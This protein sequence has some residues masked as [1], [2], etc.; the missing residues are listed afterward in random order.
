MADYNYYEILG[1]DKSASDDDIKAAYRK[2]AKKYHPDLYTTKSDAEK[3]NAEEMFKKVNHAYQVLSDPQK[4]A[5]Y[6]QYGSED[7][8]QF[9][10]GSQGFSAGFGG[11]GDVF[12]DIFSQFTGGSRR[13]NPNE[14]R[15]G[16]DIQVRVSIEFMESV[17]GV[18]HDLKFRRRETCPTCHGT[19]AKSA[20]SIK[21]CSRCNGTGRVRV[22]TNTIFG[23]MVQE[24]ECPDCGGKG[25][26]IADKCQECQGKGFV[27]NI[28]TVHSRIPAGISDGQS[29]VHQGEGDCG[30]NGGM[31][32]NLIV[33]INVKPHPLYTRRNNDLLYEMP[34]SYVVA[35]LG[36]DLDVPTPYGNV[37]YKIPEGT[38]T[39]AVFKIKGKGMKSVSRDAYGDLYVTVKVVTPTKLTRAQRDSLAAF[40]DSLGASQEESI[41]KF[42]STFGGNV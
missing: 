32:G 17:K 42:K 10:G 18:Q 8:P 3:K 6:D 27:Y 15:R 5:A 2:M 7:G 24:S 19:G 33:Q 39:G 11:F 9:A 20:S 21:T 40:G 16:D 31:S 13:A 22:R 34:I 23:S 38:Q 26:T 36:G 30:V 4:K 37:T 35:A 14:P 25:K 28:R 1:V 29:F 12:S 41:K